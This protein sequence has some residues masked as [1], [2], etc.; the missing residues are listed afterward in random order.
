MWY[1]DSHEKAAAIMQSTS[2]SAM[3]RGTRD[4]L[5]AKR[6]GNSLNLTALRDFSAKR[7]TGSLQSIGE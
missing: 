6:H 7:D 2:V 1:F 5:R 3:R 4:L